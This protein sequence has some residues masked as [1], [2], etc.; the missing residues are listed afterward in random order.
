[1][2]YNIYRNNMFLFDDKDIDN[3]KRR[4]KESQFWSKISQ[5][6]DDWIKKD[7]KNNMK[8]LNQKSLHISSLMTLYWKLVQVPVKSLFI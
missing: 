8:S 2:I 5:K 7:F 4:K 6:Y 1:M 3:V